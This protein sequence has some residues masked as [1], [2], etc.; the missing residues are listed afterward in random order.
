MVAEGRLVTRVSPE[1]GRLLVELRARVHSSPKADIWETSLPNE[2]AK[3]YVPAPD[4]PHRGEKLH[5][6]LANRPSSPG[7]PEEFAIAWPTALLYETD[8][9]VGFSMRR[10]RDAKSIPALYNQ[11]LRKAQ[12]ADIDWWCM[13]TA[14]RTIASVCRLLHNLGYAIGDLRAE[15]W[16]VNSDML[17][18][19]VSTDNLQV[20]DPLTGELYYSEAQAAEYAPPEILCT[21]ATRERQPQHDV[22]AMAVL[23]YQLLMGQHP[24]TGGAY[25]GKGEPPSETIARMER[26]WWL[27]GTH[28]PYRAIATDLPFD[29][30]HPV[31]QAMFRRCFDDGHTLPGARPSARE[32]EAALKIAIDSLAWCSNVRTHV[33]SGHHA[34]CSWCALDQAAGYDRWPFY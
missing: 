20:C 33:Y 32:W 29:V 21:A 13:H 3:I 23:I 30:L 28:S 9:I 5:V 7:S 4:S 26:G 8:E 16:L 34:R 10:L 6:M 25:W 14:A 18:V 17:V 22:F 27:Y 31:L 11:K 12:A 19:L 15:N 24:F 1:N 2:L